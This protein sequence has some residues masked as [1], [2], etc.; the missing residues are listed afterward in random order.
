MK[1][2]ASHYNCLAFRQ[3]FRL[4][5]YMHSAAPMLCIS[6]HAPFAFTIG[7]NLFALLALL[8][9]TL[10]LELTFHVLFALPRF[11]ERRRTF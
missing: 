2:R 1:S 9:L 4:L 10:P 8:L 3:G 5:V 11:A 6:F 7:L